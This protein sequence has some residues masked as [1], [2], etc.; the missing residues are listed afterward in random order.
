MDVPLRL[1]GGAHL[2]YSRTGMVTLA[3]VRSGG[4]QTV[5][6]DQR[7]TPKVGGLLAPLGTFDFAATGAVTVSNRD[8][9]GYVVIDAV[10]WF[11]AAK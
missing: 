11:P 3:R 10:Q 4:K 5:V 1:A 9:D 7:E 6:I 8:A 2:A